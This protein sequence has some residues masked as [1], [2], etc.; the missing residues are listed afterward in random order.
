MKQVGYALTLIGFTCSCLHASVIESEN[1]KPAIN[2][3][4]SLNLI[5]GLITP[6]NS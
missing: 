3:N 5:N 2:G 6:N 4:R 1:K